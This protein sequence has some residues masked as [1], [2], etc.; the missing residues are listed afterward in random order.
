MASENRKLKSLNSLEEERKMNMCKILFF[1]KKKY[2]I[3][4]LE[5]TLYSCLDTESSATV[6]NNSDQNS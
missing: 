1:K 5:A 6:P 2:G 3:H 4:W